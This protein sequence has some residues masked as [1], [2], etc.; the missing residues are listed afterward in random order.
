M[1]STGERSTILMLATTKSSTTTAEPES[2]TTI[3]TTTEE[4]GLS[5]NLPWST[6]GIALLS[7]LTRLSCTRLFI[8]SDDTLYGV[9]KDR[10]Y[11]WKLSKNAKYATVV[12][13]VHE[14][15]GSNSVKL[16][17]SEDV[18]VDRH[19]SI[20]VL[21]TNNHRVQK[22][23]NGTTHAIT[24]AG[25]T[26]SGGCSLNQLYYPR[27]FAFDPTDTFMYIADRS[28]HRV[29]RFLTNSTSGTDGIVVAGTGT[30]IP[31]NTNETLNGPWS[32]RYLSS[33][34][35]GLLIV[36]HNGHS[37]IRWP[38]GATSGTFVAGLPGIS[39]SN[40]TCLFEPADVRI[41]D[42]LNMYVVEQKNHRVQM[43]C[44]DSNVSVT[45]VGNGTPGN[46]PTQLDGPRGMAFD[47]EMNM[48]VCDTGSKR[49]QKFLK[50]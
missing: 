28:C 29:V 13:G 24:I 35:Y 45:V 36:N 43:F 3:T 41:D 22:F 50:R 37:V 8:D 5:S 21:D 25:L 27:G 19:G 44:K 12:A 2:T 48:Y 20:Y 17:Y 40:S 18:Y 47:S 1:M 30:G 10:H 34:H 15:I 14:S 26:G 6:T 42:N 49:V 39:C 46:S 11:V 4:A 7:A 9:D 31:D 38:L 33:I 32:I 23:M 16:N